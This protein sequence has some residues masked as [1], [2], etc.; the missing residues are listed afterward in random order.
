MCGRA[1]CTLSPA[2]A[3]RAFGFP[4]TTTVGGAG[5]GGGEDAPAVP[6]LQMDRFRPSYNVSPGAYLPVGAVRARAPGDDGD[7]GGGAEEHVPVIQCMK[8]GLV[9]SFTGKNEKLDHFRMFNARS[10]SIK[11]KAS[12]RRLIPK[13]RCLVAVEGFFEWKKD[14]SK[15]Q[16]YYIYFQDQRPL[17]FAALFDTWKNSEGENLHTFTILTTRSSTSLAWLHDRMP[18]ILGDKDSVNAWLHNSSLKLEEITVPYE[19]ADLV[20]YPVTTAMG[21]PSFNGSECIKEVQ[22]R[23]SGKPISEFFLKKSAAHGQLV[24]P[25]KTSP[26]VAETQPFRTAKE[27]CDELG[28]N[29]PDKTDEQWPAEKQECS[30]AV[31][32]EPATLEPQTLYT[33]H[34]IKRED[35]PESNQKQDISGIKRKIQDAEVKAETKAENT[36]RS[37]VGPVKRKEKGPKTASDGQASL[38]SF[39]AKK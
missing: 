32:D 18:V 6:T 31:K 37:P 17:V 38:L 21:K 27:E 16:P 12:F 3:A 33:A 35:V 7:G 25:D 10:E 9:P 30:T 39:F 20:W 5:G 13:N 22:L 1:R 28:E 15:K 2:Q 14:G 8:W 11:E 19:G 36:G 24:K 4:S 29:Q 26:E 34:N 23:P